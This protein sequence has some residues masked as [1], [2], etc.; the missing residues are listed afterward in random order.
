MKKA[1][2]ANPAEKGG[3]TQEQVVLHICNFC[4]RWSNLPWDCST[5]SGF[6]SACSGAELSWQHT[7]DAPGKGERGCDALKPWE[8]GR[9][10]TTLRGKGVSITPPRLS[11]A[12]VGYLTSTRNQIRLM[13]RELAAEETILQKLL[14]RLIHEDREEKGLFLTRTSANALTRP[15]KGLYNTATLC[16]LHFIENKIIW[17]D[18]IRTQEKIKCPPTRTWY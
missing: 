15:R 5:R 10:V 9:G 8:K 2:F 3:V 14:Q 16:L 7:D 4:Q 12:G 18:S 13:L 11:M 6:C 17:Q 1:V